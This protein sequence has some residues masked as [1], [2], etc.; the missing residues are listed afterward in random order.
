MNCKC[1][2]IIICVCPLKLLFSIHTKYIDNLKPDD[3]VIMYGCHVSLLFCYSSHQCP[4]NDLVKAIEAT[5]PIV[6]QDWNGD[7]V[8]RI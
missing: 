4:D 1:C 6:L 7:W 8:R 3:V 2:Q 5:K